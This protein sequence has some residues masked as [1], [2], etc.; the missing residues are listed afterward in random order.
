MW[1]WGCGYGGLLQGCMHVLTRELL[2]M[3]AHFFKK[4]QLLGKVTVM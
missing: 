1:G 2:V 4:L 3:K